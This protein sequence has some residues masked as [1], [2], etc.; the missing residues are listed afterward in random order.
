M[1]LLFVDDNKAEVFELHV[2]RDEAVR[3]DDEV[4]TAAFEFSQD[5]ILLARRSESRE[6]FNIDRKT[7][8]TL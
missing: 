1:L 8:H 7:F 5:L 6:Q 2:F 4:Y 3:A